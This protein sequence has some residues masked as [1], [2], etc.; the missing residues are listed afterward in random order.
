MVTLHVKAANGIH[1]VRG[2][3]GASHPQALLIKTRFGIHTFGLRFPI[4]LA[5]LDHDGFVQT[6]R[7][8]FRPN[9]IFLWSPRYSR[10][11]ELPEGTIEKKQ[12]KKGVQITL[13]F[14]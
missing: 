1:K 5:V 11:L 14:E 2:L 9:G 8:G 3:I 6:I 7:K 13:V 12:I 10:I 4:D